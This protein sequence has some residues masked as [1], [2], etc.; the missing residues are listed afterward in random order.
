MVTTPAT[1]SSPALHRALDYDLTIVGGGI[2]G[3]TLACSLQASG[4]RIALIEARPKAAGFQ[5]RRAYAITLLSGRIF[6]QLGIWDDVLPQITT[7]QQIRLA[8]ELHPEV[9]QLRPTDLGTS[10]LGY[11]AEHGVLLRSLHRRLEAGAGVD[12]L[13][14]ATVQSVTYEWDQATLTVALGDTVKT[15]TSRLVVAADGARSPLRHQAGIQTRGWKY[16]QSCVTVVLRPEQSHQNIAREH[17]WASG[18]F[19][20]LPLPG[21]RCQIVLTAPHREAQRL[22]EMPEADFIAE[23]Q[24]RYQGQ[25]GEINLVS[26]RQLF[27]VQLMHSDR[28]VQHRL[29]L[30]GD[31]AHCCHPVG[32]Q[33]MNLGIR[34]A[35]ALAQVLAQAHQRG[36][37]IGS[38]RILQRYERWRRLETLSIL[39]FTDFLDRLFS[40]DW[41]W[42]RGLRRLGLWLMNR[43]GL[44]RHLALRLMTGLSGRLPDLAN[45]P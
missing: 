24:H 10:E 30:V 26:D 44:I 3:L 4:L 38:L 7:F 45:H 39:L 12:W 36:Q 43:I 35:A 9:V 6:N 28:Y 31:A 16:W 8:E 25:L 27:P 19:A 32:G 11:V 40:N 15:L 2:V 42:L 41:G 5:N 17:F 22:L 20:T 34:D 14:P 13:C 37:D 23:L 33:G 29:A 21:N 18:P 1:A